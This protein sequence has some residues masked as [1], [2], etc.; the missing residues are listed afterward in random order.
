MERQTTAE[1]YE[2]MMQSVLFPDIIS[3]L[4]FCDGDLTIAWKDIRVVL[5]ALEDPELNVGVIGASSLRTVF[6]ALPF[7]EVPKAS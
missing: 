1:Y 3:I 2:I 7:W 6:S 5:E 4:N